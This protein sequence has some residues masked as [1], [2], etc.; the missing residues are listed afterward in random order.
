[1]S[2][3]KMYW[4]KGTPIADYELP[5]GYSMV[6]YK[7][8]T[9][10]KAAW[11]ECCKNGLVGDDTAPEF[12]DDCVADVDDCIPEKDVFFLDFDGEHIGTIAAIYHPEGNYGQVH[13]VG[14][15]TEFRGKGLGKYL[16]NVAVKKL[17]A[18]GVDYIYL[19]TDEW[20]MGAVKS[21]LTAGFIPVEYEED[22]DMKGRWEW[23]LCE[24]GVDSVDMVYEDCSFCRKLEKAPVVKV[25]VVGVGRGR[26]MINHCDHV[27][28]AKTVAICDNYDILLDKAKKDYADRDITFYDNYEDFLNHDMDVV[29][30]ANF[31]TEH[32]P[33]AVK[34][35]EKGFHVLSEVLPVLTMK[36]A[37]ELIEAVERTG[38]KYFYAENYCYMGAPKKMKELYEEGELGEFE[39]GEGEYMHNCEDIWHNITFGDPDHWRNTMHA[40]YYCT[41]SIGP[42]IH[43]TGLKPVKVTGFELPFNARMAR[44]GAKAGPVGIEMITLENGAILKSIHGVGPSRN[45]VWY[46]IYGSKGRMECAREDPCESGHV[47]KLYVNVDEYEGQ[48]INEPEERSTGDCFSRLAAPSGHGGSD[49]Y[50]MHNVVETVRGRENMDVIDV[51]EAM[52]MF[53]PGMF[54]YRSVLQGGIPLDIPDL[55]NPEEREKWRNDTE[56]TVAKAA[57]DMLVPGYSK[58]NPDIPAETYEGIKK[59]F[60][61]EW[62]KKIAENK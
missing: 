59:K 35:L 48:N 36:E 16:N 27:K 44:M 9:E 52:D 49:W 61:E 18:Q 62:A 51:Y 47:N 4:L 17:N 19:T 6:N 26:T 2:Q 30:L 28:G 13:M 23:M 22:E 12:F 25:G 1:M 34:A 8:C 54:A 11:V 7:E 42:L 43:I 40:C 39:Y 38:K 21:Y 56:C 20:R 10:D 14:I 58:G 32:A 37:V 46:S 24:L 33:F 45:S 57:G 41:H 29:V 55:R 3:L 15:K 53:L 50:V 5:E 60:E 31:A